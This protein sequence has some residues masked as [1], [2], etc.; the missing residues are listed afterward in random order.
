MNLMQTCD[1]L[2]M[3]NGQWIEHHTSA[4]GI[5]KVFSREGGRCRFPA[6][7]SPEGAQQ[8]FCRFFIQEIYLLYTI[9]KM[10]DRMIQA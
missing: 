4:F 3:G 5:F 10:M 2:I 6:D 7:A 9:H 1:D 8:N